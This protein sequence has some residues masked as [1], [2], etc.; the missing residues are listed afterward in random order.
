MVFI[1]TADVRIAAAEK[2]NSYQGVVFTGF[3]RD[4]I[5][6]LDSTEVA[7]GS[8]KMLQEADQYLGLNIKIILRNFKF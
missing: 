4:N 6:S 3:D 1:L 8:L 5:G 7:A 2:L